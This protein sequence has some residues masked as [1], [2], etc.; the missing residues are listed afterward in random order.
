MKKVIW[1]IIILVVVGAVWYFWP[2]SSVVDDSVIVDTQ[3]TGTVS[4]VVPASTTPN[5]SLD[6]VLSANFSCGDL[7]FSANFVNTPDASS[8]NFAANGVNY[9]LPQVVSADGGRYEKD[10]VEFWVK[11][12]GATLTLN[13]EVKTCSVVRS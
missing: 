11:G 1:L 8:V 4:D 6:E 13:G 5:L 12:E 9:D 7:T 10:G 3:A 2:K